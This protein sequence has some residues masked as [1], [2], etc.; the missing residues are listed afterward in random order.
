MGTAFIGLSR[1]EE[2]AAAIEEALRLS[3]A[4]KGIAVW[5]TVLVGAYIRL[6]RLDEAGA[7]I[8]Q[9]MRCDPS[10]FPLHLSASLLAV[11]RGDKT[12]AERHAREACRLYPQL[13]RQTTDRLAGTA[14]A[15]ELIDW[16]EA[17]S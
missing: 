11:R 9:A 13:D 16:I 8:D 5:A 12:T 15:R 7:S 3:L 6:G 4:Y 2:G 14:G 10:F 1:L 17:S